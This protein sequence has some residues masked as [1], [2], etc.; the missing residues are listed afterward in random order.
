MQKVVV[1]LLSALTVVY[2]F[3]LPSKLFN[4]PVCT[5][6]E[7]KNGNLLGAH[8]A[9]DTQWRFPLSNDVP[10]K[11]ATALITFEDKRFY[12][13]WGFDIVAFCRAA[14]LNIKKKEIISGGSTITMQVIRLSRKNQPRTI[15]EKIKEIILATRVEFSYRKK[16]I[17]A[18][19]A[20]NAPYGGNIVGLN[21]A[22]W[23]Y[24][25]RSANKL[26]WAESAMLAVL[27]NSPALIHPRRNRNDLFNKR[28]RL[29]KKLYEKGCFDSE[30]YELAIEEP[31]PDEPNPFP[32]HA[33][34]LLSRAISENQ[35]PNSTIRTTIDLHYQERINRLVNQYFKRLSTNEIYSIAVLVVKVETGEVVSYIGNV[36]LPDDTEHGSQV[37]V[38][39]ADRSTGSILKPFLYASMLTSGDILP[40]TLVPD[41]PTFMSGYM[42][43]NFNLGYD[44]AVR[45]Q[46]ALARSLNVPAV[47]LLQS[48]GNE[49][50][51]YML[52]KIGLTSIT[53]SAAHYGLS[54][55]LGGCEGK[56]WDITGAYASM[57]RTLNH[58][59]LFNGK[60]NPLDLH[61]PY[62]LLTDKKEKTPDLDPESS[63][64][65]A[66]A[67]WLT[68]DAMLDV[69]RP[70]SENAWRELESSER[71]AW[72]TG[73][74][75]GF[76]DAWS[77]GVTPDYVVGV[78]VGNADGEGR[79]G[80]TGIQ[81]AA[82]L[83]FDIF[84]I[85]PDTKTWFPKP[86][87]EMSLEPICHESGYLASTICP[88]VDSLWI[89]ETGVRFQVCPF[90]QI[91]HLDASG[92][93]RVHSDCE[94]TEAMQHVAWFVLPPSIEWYYKSRN[95]S[96]K[97]LPPYREDCIQNLPQAT[98]AALE[99]IYPKDKERIAVPR[100]LDGSRGKTIFEVAHR[101]K[102]TIIFWYI[103]EEYIGQT[104]DFHQFALSPAVGK[105]TLTLVDENGD[106]ISSSF[107]IVEN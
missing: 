93:W 3:I 22:S 56:L 104:K 105:H 100:E 85:L 24:F 45:A 30:T 41:I 95:S 106:R 107:E 102:N 9:S 35:T 87:D 75:F 90:H 16:T 62:Y 57:A 25:G 11:V 40:E 42:P 73:T 58:Y 52:R 72:K 98:T 51:H 7:D 83:L 36:N 23:Y 37:D 89:P 92:K 60:Y 53:R 103:D 88:N 39:V 67:I 12:Y 59:T 27:P 84:D 49:R 81:A 2:I 21:T 50:F 31:I 48:Y 91:I 55:I 34:H 66:A 63:W 14:Y 47:R 38:I 101:R 65:S 17:L 46:R 29:L 5:V 43:Q 77:V 54:L 33:S 76:R 71:I 64:F 97:T 78:W 70:G 10:E 61:S 79:P 19:Y 80:I 4:D 15:L 68:F 69:E 96:Y 44:G 20:A 26:S 94:A 6:I 74:S 8:I 99:M 28:N 82:P 86:Y 1:G 13:H 18:L 32:Q